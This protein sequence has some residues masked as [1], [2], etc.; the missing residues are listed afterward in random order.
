MVHVLSRAVPSDPG[1][2]EITR[3]DAGECLIFVTNS[4]PYVRNKIPGSVR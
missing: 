3:V 2:P 1:R 4:V